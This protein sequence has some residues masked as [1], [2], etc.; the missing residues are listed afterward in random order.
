MK[1]PFLHVYLL[2]LSAPQLIAS[3]LKPMEEHTK[4]AKVEEDAARLPVSFILFLS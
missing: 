2:M 3:L 1:C 4:D